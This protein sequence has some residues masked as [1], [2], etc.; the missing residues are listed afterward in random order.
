M[1]HS[2]DQIWSGNKGSLFIGCPCLRTISQEYRRKQVAVWLRACTECV[3]KENG[4]RFQR[5]A[6]CYLR[7]YKRSVLGLR[8]DVVLRSVDLDI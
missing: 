2:V 3:H 1:V 5:S 4:G 7:D 6:R 8:R